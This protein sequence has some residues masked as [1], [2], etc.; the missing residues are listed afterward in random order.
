MA[1]VLSSYAQ[2]K[3][4]NPAQRSPEPQAAELARNFAVEVTNRDG[5]AEI[6]EK[7]S[8]EREARAFVRAFNKAAGHKA[9][10]R[11]VPMPQNPAKA[12]TA[13]AAGRFA[14][15]GQTAQRLQAL[16]GNK[17]TVQF[18]PLLS[19]PDDPKSKGHLFEGSIN[20]LMDHVAEV[21]LDDR[22]A[23]SLEVQLRDELYR[24]ADFYRRLG[25]GV[26]ESTHLETPTIELDGLTL[27]D[28]PPQARVM[29]STGPAVGPVRCYLIG[30]VGGAI[31]HVHDAEDEHFAQVF[32]DEFNRIEADDSAGYTAI[33][34]KQADAMGLHDASIAAPTT[35]TDR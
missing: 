2:V 14:E 1:T 31:E 18:A 27:I 11:V 28:L 21:S 34:Q 26:A 19:W 4:F 25:D 35:Y 20:R 24:I 23:E 15:Q 10:A 32:V 29:A 5:E 33:T 8:T 7:N 16:T 17:I 30:K 9:R 6:V 12:K 22:Q 13:G 3:E